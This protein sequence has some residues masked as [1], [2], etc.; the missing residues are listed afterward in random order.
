MLTYL[1][2]GESHGPQ[3][4]AVM[5][6]L[7]S[8]LSVNI[9]QINFQLA[10]RQKGYGRGGRMK[11]E[12]DQVQIVSGIR[13]G[14]TIGGPITFVIPNRDWVNWKRIMHPVND[15]PDDLS[16]GERRLAYQ[17]SCPR[18]GHADLAGAVKWNHH[19]MRNVLE[20]ASARETAARVALGA[21]S[22]QLLEHFG[23]SIAS[24]VVRI[25]PVALDRKSDLSDLGLVTSVTEASEVRCLDKET[26]ERM[27]D[28]IDEAKEA[29]DSLGGVAEIIIRGL[30]VGLGGFSQW[31]DRLDGQLAGAM[32]AIHSVKGV[33]IGMGFEMATRHGS[34]VHDQIFHDPEGS[35]NR[36]YFYRS[37]N[38]AGGIEGGITNGEDIIIRVASK[39]ISTLTRP[40]ATVDVRSKEPAIAMVERTDN[41]VVPAL[42]VIGETVASLVLAEAFL[43]KF[44][45][46]N[47]VETERNYRSFIKSEF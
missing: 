42:A 20:R 28:A 45:S 1:T 26:G 29:G 35:R 25:G 4:T 18:P 3:L 27:K 39:P 31:Y 22:R 14:V 38:N 44:G 46:D 23:V 21:L 15:L 32:M 47:M 6:G 24:H 43:Q 2:S 33:E 12:N 40:L 11:I 19:D 17:T 41:C 8:G 37:S 10:R 7:P 5:D 9:D 30:P 16:P 36:K 13:G 34:E